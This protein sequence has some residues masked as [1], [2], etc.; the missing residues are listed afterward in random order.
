VDY[1]FI[2]LP[3]ENLG[4]V[5]DKAL[6]GL[7]SWMPIVLVKEC[8][9]CGEVKGLEEFYFHKGN[10]DNRRKD[11]KECHIKQGK[12]RDQVPEVKARKKSQK[13]EYD[14]T[15]K[16]K[17]KK[18]EYS[19]RPDIKIQ[20]E[21]RR[22]T[23]EAKAKKEEYDQSPERKALTNKRHKERRI[24]DLNFRIAANLRSNT[25][26]AIKNGQ[27]AGSFVDDLCCSIEEFKTKVASFFKPGMSWDGNW[28]NGPGKWNLDH[29]VPLSWFDLS[30]REQFKSAAHYNNYQPLWWE[31][32]LIKGDKYQ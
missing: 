31:E 28:G 16:R 6:E 3:Q 20:A 22:Q 5:Y 29:I 25:V 17:A 24:S 19:Q 15:P 1:P 2:P 23:P 9:K 8:K 21:K 11:C 12:E 10:R 13:K 14:Q 30:N 32:N 27:K 18:R 4:P 7:G 26:Y